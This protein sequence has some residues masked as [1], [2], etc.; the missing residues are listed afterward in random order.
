VKAPPHV[1][2]V[3]WA[4][5]SQACSSATPVGGRAE[6]RSAIR[7]DITRG[8][9]QSSVPALGDRGAVSVLARELINKPANT[10]RSR[11]TKPTS[12]RHSRRR[13]QR[14]E[15]RLSRMDRCV[16]VAISPTK[17]SS[18]DD[19]P[20]NFAHFG[21]RAGDVRLCR[22]RTVATFLTAPGTTTNATRFGLRRLQR[23]CRI[24]PQ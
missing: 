12:A 13:P 1:S 11:S 21:R 5:C 22:A 18:T 24:P 20:D 15:A 6:R 19:Q 23:T 2:S 10:K 7:G 16:T 9:C 14:G 8:G 4:E 3:L 17:G